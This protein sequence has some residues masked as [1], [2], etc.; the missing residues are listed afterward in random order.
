MWQGHHSSCDL[1]RHAADREHAG[2][3]RSC[4]GRQQNQGQVDPA[5]D[6]EVDAW[7]HPDMVPSSC[8]QLV[9]LLNGA[10][11]IHD[12]QSLQVDP[13]SLV[14]LGPLDCS[15]FTSR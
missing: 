14:F 6:D 1:R 12:R 13:D 4:D 10:L 8:R 2:R 3:L 7:R 5:G 11:R 9:I 15:V